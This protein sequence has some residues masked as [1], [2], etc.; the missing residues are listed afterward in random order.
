MATPVMAASRVRSG[1]YEPMSGTCNCNA[2]CLVPAF[3]G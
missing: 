2:K 3:D 1:D